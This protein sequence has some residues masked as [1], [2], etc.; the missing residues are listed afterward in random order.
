MSAVVIAFPT[1]SFRPS[2]RAELC[3]WDKAARGIAG[4]C[5]QDPDGTGQWIETDEQGARA[6]ITQGRRTGAA[7]L[8]VLP[9]RGR[10]ELIECRRFALLGTFRTLRECLEAICRTLPNAPPRDIAGDAAGRPRK[11]WRLA[12]QP[13]PENESAPSL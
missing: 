7:L 10:W 9:K 2:D 8:C 11:T 6:W 3:R 4:F 13:E 1:D 12:I 5:V